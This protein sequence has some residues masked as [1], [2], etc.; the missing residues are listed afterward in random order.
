MRCILDANTSTK[1][2]GVGGHLSCRSPF[3]Y[4]AIFQHSMRSYK[5][6]KDLKKGMTT[7]YTRPQCSLDLWNLYSHFIP[8]F[9]Q[10]AMGTRTVHIFLRILIQSALQSLYKTLESNSY[11]KLYDAWKMTNNIQL[12]NKQKDTQLSERQAVETLC[13][14]FLWTH[15]GWGQLSLVHQPTSGD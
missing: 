12:G 14:R 10:P 11:G 1:I 13:R 8:V 6:T 2:H 7:L 3:L 5:L 4:W 9:P 15:A